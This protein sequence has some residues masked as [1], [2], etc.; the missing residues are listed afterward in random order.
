M[1]EELKKAADHFGSYANLAR[2]LGVTPQAVHLWRRRVVPPQRI[3]QIEEL[4]GIKIPSP[5]EGG[6]V[7]NKGAG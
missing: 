5:P 1:N 3:K 2:V 4:T 6:D 7:D